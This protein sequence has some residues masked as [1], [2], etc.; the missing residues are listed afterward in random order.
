MHELD[1]MDWCQEYRAARICPNAAN[2]D[3]GRIRAIWGDFGV[4]ESLGERRKRVK[5]TE[6]TDL[7]GDPRESRKRTRNRAIWSDFER[8]TYWG[9]LRSE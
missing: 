5:M 2:G 6:K 8:K 7:A 1:K 4:L 3:S 9:K